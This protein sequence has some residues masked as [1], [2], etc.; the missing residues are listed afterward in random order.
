MTDWG[1]LHPSVKLGAG[2]GGGGG[3]NDAGDHDESNQGETLTSLFLKKESQFGSG[4]QFHPTGA[5]DFG[6]DDECVAPLLRCSV[7]MLFRCSGY[8]PSLSCSSSS[9]LDPPCLASTRLVSLGPSYFSFL[10]VLLNVGL[11]PFPPFFSFCPA[12][13]FI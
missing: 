3:D 4:P 8:R 13:P 5:S 6:S 9:G 10:W 11:R 2:G 1:A 12:A 7:P